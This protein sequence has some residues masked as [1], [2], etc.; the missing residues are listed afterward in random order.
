MMNIFDGFRTTHQINKIEYIPYETIRRLMP[1]DL[2]QKNLRSFALT[3]HNP[4]MRGTSQ[5][6]EIFFQA[7]VAA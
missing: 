2:A 4:I 3:A 6:P 5:R 7:A 1:M